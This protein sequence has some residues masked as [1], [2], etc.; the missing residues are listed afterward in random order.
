MFLTGRLDVIEAD[1]E[2]VLLEANP[3][4]SMPAH[5]PR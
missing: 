1:G 3:A 5:L 4:F 2:Y